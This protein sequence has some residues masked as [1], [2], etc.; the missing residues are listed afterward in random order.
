MTTNY[1][2]EHNFI[3]SS[4]IEKNPETVIS[5]CLCHVLHNASSKAAAFGNVVKGTAMQI[6]RAL[7]NGRLRVSKV[8]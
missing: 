5:G 4:A 3:K 2:R 1:T 8:S 7:I 6:E